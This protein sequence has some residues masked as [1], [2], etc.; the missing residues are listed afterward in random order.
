[1]VKRFKHLFSKGL[2]FVNK[3]HERSVKAK[4]N[5]VASFGIKAIGLIISL[6]KVPII[7]SYLNVDKY[8]VWLT[9]ASI[10]DWVQYF[11]LGIGQGLRNKFAITLAQNDKVKARKLVST[12]Y[13]YVSIIFGLLAIILI[14]IVIFLNWQEILKVDSISNSELTYSIL[15]VFIMFVFRFVFNLI[16]MILKADQ[17]PALA[18][19]FLPLGSIITLIIVSILG[20]FSKDSLFLACCAIAIPPV[21]TVFV[22]NLALFNG[23]YKQ[24]KPRYRFVDK[25]LFNE[26][27]SL[28][29]KFF[30]IQ[31]AGLIM[32]STSN[33][34]LTRIV[35]PTEVSLFNIARQYYGMPF[36]FFG[37]ILTPFWSAIT[38]AYARNEYDWIERVM[39]RLLKYSVLFSLGIILM[40][41]F[42]DIA[43]RIWLRGKVVIP[44]SISISMTILNI[45]YVFF[46]PYSNFIN[47]VGK[48]NLGL[49]VAVIKTILFLPVAIILTKQFNATGL[50]MALLF[51]N[52]LPSSIIDVIQYKKII[53]RSAHGIWNR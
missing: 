3:G 4:K 24:Y 15:L 16:T 25:T 7:L 38:D 12:A 22:A 49:R 26:V 36:L 6:V 44:F 51:V 42:S 32:F 10:V 20:T 28:G 35:N 43:F 19:T 5:I 37:I 13:Y 39:K 46:S 47:G 45:F 11:D 40:L 23:Q 8:G 18:D 34:I 53:N 50:I 1:M 33:I 27:F 2:S 31:I 30:L 21:L 17:K 52:S 29:L 9:I 41:L 48:L 14:P